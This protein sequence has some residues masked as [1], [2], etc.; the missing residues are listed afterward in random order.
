MVAK[1]MSLYVIILDP[2]PSCPASSIA[3]QQILADFK[4][5]QAIFD[6]SK[7]CDIITY[8]IESANSKSL[9][10]LSE[11]GYPVH[12]SPQTLYIIQDKYKQKLFL[13]T[14]KIKVPKFT[15]VDSLQSLKSSCQEYGYPVLLKARQDSYDGR[16]NYLITKEADIQRGYDNFKGRECM[17]EEFVKY[18]KELSVMVSRN[19][20]GDIASFPV[21]ENFHVNNILD[22]TIAPARVSEDIVKSS[23]D[24]A[25]ETVG[26]L[27]G[28]GIFGIELFLTVDGKIM[29]NEIA[30]RP[31]NSGHYSIDACS[32]SQ[33]EQ[34]I[35][36][37]LNWP[38]YDQTLFSPAVMINILGP[39]GISGYYRI[40]GLDK[41]MA[42]PGSKVHL[43]GKKITKPNRKL[44]HITIVG[45]NVDNILANAN[46]IKTWIRIDALNDSNDKAF[47]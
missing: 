20:S 34:H 37:I 21:V 38:I 41:V 36:S 24:I 15:I 7:K 45:E 23:I 39:K 26:L 44:G 4:D 5:E 27:K 18:E 25:K 43:Y 10:K 31:H 9:N 12:P 40:K 32:I 35:R 17:V 8:E 30:P 3:D 16:G 6:L 2:E 11:I 33:F 13:E 42:L 1:R 14:N 29:I 19:M 28:S 47:D 46:L 22:T